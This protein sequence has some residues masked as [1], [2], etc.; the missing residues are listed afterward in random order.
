MSGELP[1]LGIGV[2]IGGTSTKAAVIDDLGRVIASVVMPTVGGADG[3]VATATQAA[4][5]VARS[6]EIAVSEV[7]VIGVGIPGTVDPGHGTVRFAVNVGIGREDI[8]LGARLASGLGVA[9]HLENDVRA[10]ALGADWYLANTTGPVNDLAYLSIGTGIAAGYVERGSVRRGASFVAGEIGHIPIDPNGPPCVCG[11]VGCIEAMSS[12]SAIERMWPTSTGSSAIAL[13]RAAS[14]G[15]PTAG[16]LWAGVVAGL[17]RA[18]LLL[19]LTWDPEVVVLGGGVAALGNELRD[20][21]AGAVGGRCPGF[22]VPRL[23]PPRRANAG[24]RIVRA[25]RS[26]RGNPRRACCTPLAAVMTSFAIRGANAQVLVDGT[27]IAAVDPPDRDQ[28]ESVVMD[29]TDCWVLPGFVDLQVNGAVGVDLATEPTRVGEVASFLVQCGVTS[30][31]PTVISSSVH[32]TEAA[33][34]AI[35]EWSHLEPR[36]WARSLGVHLE[37]PFLNPVRAGAHPVHRLRHP[38]LEAIDGW[39]RDAGVAM[40]T[41]APELP[42]AREVIE[43]L[44]STGVVVC[45]GHSDAAVADMRDA[46]AAGVTGVTHLFNAM[47]PITARSPG[48]AGA[49]LADA[50]LIAGLIV[51][52]IHVDPTM[53]RLAWRALGPNRIA[54]VTDAIAA[55]GLAPGAY[56]VGETLVTVDESGARTSNGVLA[57]SVLRFDEAVRNLIAFTGCALSEA[58]M[59]A[60]ATPARLARRSDVGRLVPGCAADIV[61]L[62]TRLQV[63]ATIV[64]GRVVFDPHQRY[65]PAWPDGA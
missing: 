28:G 62:D 24:D 47:S 6:A 23:S 37:G 45:V 43:R 11:Q 49:T 59:A 40:V 38:T 12:G 7:K 51:D 33:L 27:R 42:H 55:L 2:D 50:A 41:I 54:L 56:R 65:G 10:A 5:D 14:S 18:V 21:I 52:G 44:V 16:R 63:A 4:I 15:D 22:R 8:E 58:S 46:V 26:D 60:S 3:V 29:A 39:H 48:V 31:M 1:T 34:S 57:G 19:A 61:L 64:D 36:G 25:A 9:V 30:F 13:C 20:A 35:R 32:D 17:S 53:V